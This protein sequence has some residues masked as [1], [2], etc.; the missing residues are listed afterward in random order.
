[1]PLTYKHQVDIW[2][3]I[4]LID[5]MCRKVPLAL[6]SAIC[7]SIQIRQTWVFFSKIALYFWKLLISCRERSYL[8]DIAY[9][10]LPIYH[11]G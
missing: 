1:M 2:R 10:H 7:H 5:N 6:L 11:G 8:A 9:W 3:V 4:I